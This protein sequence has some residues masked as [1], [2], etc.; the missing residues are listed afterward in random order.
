[1]PY[2]ASTE[3]RIV[4]I[5][6]S[7][8][9]PGYARADE[10]M[11]AVY[12]PSPLQPETGRVLYV[13]SRGSAGEVM[14]AVR[15]LVQR[16]D[17]RVPVADL[18]TLEQFNERATPG[19]WLARAAAFLGLIALGLTTIGVYGVI[20]Y[21][22]GLRVQEFAVRLSL[23]AT[24]GRILHMVVGETLI[25]AAAGFL[26]GLLVALAMSPLVQEERM[27]TAID[28]TGLAG[29]LVLSLVAVFCA[30]AV[31]ALRAARVDPI[32]VLKAE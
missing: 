31:P 32:T 18:S 12:V 28:L 16:I 19:Y 6:E 1:L 22:V 8:A 11:A 20:S 3:V 15:A 17:A 5:V 23:G 29:S 30:S 21:I 24:P 4:G 7:A 13:Q 26:F 10:A 9:D 2:A 27:T 25:L 14:S